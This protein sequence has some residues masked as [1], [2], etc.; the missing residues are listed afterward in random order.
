MAHSHVSY[1]NWVITICLLA[2][3]PKGISSMQLHRD[4]G[5]KQ[6]TAWLLPHKLGKSRHTL[7]G[8]DPMS[9]PVKVDKVCQGGREKSKRADEGGESDKT[10]VVGI[11][12]RNTTR[13]RPAPET[14]RPV[15]STSLSPA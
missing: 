6:S 14:P 9:G 2:T 15:L 11:G 13:A 1:R 12:D 3:R 5:I 10:A 7:T 8:S 4:L